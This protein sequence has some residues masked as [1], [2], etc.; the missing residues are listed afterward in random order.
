[1]GLSPVTNEPVFLCNVWNKCLWTFNNMPSLELP[2]LVKNQLRR[3]VSSYC[4]C[5]YSRGLTVLSC[6]SNLL[7][8]TLKYLPLRLVMLNG[9]AE[10]KKTNSC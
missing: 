10:L 4:I 1:M 8:L 9:K 2:L 3:A 5:Q 7:P 6:I